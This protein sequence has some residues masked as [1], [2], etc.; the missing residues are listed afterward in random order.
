VKAFG[1]NT[2]QSYRRAVARKEAADEITGIIRRAHRGG[3]TVLG[4]V[5][6]RSPPGNSSRADNDLLRRKGLFIV[7][8]TD[9]PNE[10]YRPDF[11][12]FCMRRFEPQA[13]LFD[14]LRRIALAGT[15]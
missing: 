10:I 12:A 2:L 14:R 1:S 4:D 3:H 13:P 11:V 7:Q 8:E 15:K 9:L 5:L 6:A